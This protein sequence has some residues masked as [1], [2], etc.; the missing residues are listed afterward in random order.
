[1]SDT[2]FN[3]QPSSPQNIKELA[4]INKRT[5]RYC[6]FRIRMMQQFSNK[7]HQC[8]G[9]RPTRRNSDGYVH[10]KVDDPACQM[11]KKEE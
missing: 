1:M 8:C 7:V 10:I 9:K 5:C 2:L 6:D 3:I 11:F 4:K